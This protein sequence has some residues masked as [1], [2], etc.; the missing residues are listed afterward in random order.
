MVHPLWCCN[1]PPSCQHPPAVL[2]RVA[3]LAGADSAVVIAPGG[4]APRARSFSGRRDAGRGA[5]IVRVSLGVGGFQQVVPVE[6]TACA[7]ALCP[8]MA[9][10]ISELQGE[11]CVGCACFWV[12]VSLMQPLP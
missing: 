6:S 12:F 4:K 3:S 5:G 8:Q 1:L 2:G 10:N 7:K 9:E 11:P